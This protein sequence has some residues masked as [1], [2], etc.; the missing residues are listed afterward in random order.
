ML[1]NGE[2]LVCGSGAASS[3]AVLAQYPA[4]IAAV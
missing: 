2:A 3:Q 4:S 1:A